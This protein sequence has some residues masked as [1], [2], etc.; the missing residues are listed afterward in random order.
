MLFEVGRSYVM[1]D[2]RT[3]GTFGRM[4]K[5]KREMKKKKMETDRNRDN[6]TEINVRER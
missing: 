3:A 1:E 4:D 2:N 6:K 5:T